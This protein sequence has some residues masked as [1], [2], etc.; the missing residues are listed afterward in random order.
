MDAAPAK[1]KERSFCPSSCAG[2]IPPVVSTPSTTRRRFARASPRAEGRRLARHAAELLHAPTRFVGGDETEACDYVY[3]LCVG[4]EPGLLELRDRDVLD[5]PDGDRIR[6]R[7]LRV[8][9]SSLARVAAVQEVS[10][11]LDCDADAYVMRELPRDG[12]T[13]RSCSSAPRSSFTSSS[14]PT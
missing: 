7:Y 13:T 9:L 10:F 12:I 11:E 14:V 5:I 8:A 6:E 1:G 4:R 3:I 2:C